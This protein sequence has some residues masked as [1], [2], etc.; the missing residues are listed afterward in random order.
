MCLWSGDVGSR[1]PV[2]YR[3]MEGHY[4][5]SDRIV[6][7][8]P[9]VVQAFRASPRVLSRPWRP[10]GVALGPAQLMAPTLHPMGKGSGGVT[11][12]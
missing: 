2:T 11:V 9:L 7:P 1:T 5:C 6:S 10:S 8:A 4:V 3:S 12:Y